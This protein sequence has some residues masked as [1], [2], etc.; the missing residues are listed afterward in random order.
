MIERIKALCSEKK[1]TIQKLEAAAGLAN[2]SIGKW[3]K[4]SPKA[5]SVAAVASA[6]GVSM[7][8]L[9]TGKETAPAREAPELSEDEV[10]LLSAYRALPETE[11]RSVLL[12]L[13]RAAGQDPSSPASV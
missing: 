7:D 3:G 9:F 10:I 1:L 11:K 13:Q 4:A 2:G 8:Y 5:E 6:L 12:L